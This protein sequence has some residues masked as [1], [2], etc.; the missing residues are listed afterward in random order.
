MIFI[1][2]IMTF[3]MFNYAFAT[4]EAGE[5][6]KLIVKSANNN[7]YYIDINSLGYT[8]NHTV[9]AW[10]KVVPADK[11][12]VFDRFKHLRLFGF[13]NAGAQYFK[14]YCE[15]DCRRR[16]LRFLITTVY[17]GEDNIVRRDETLNVRWTSIPR[18]SSFDMIRDIVCKA[19]L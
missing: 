14:V 10:Y 7:D 13:R 3:L 18:E 1:L 16:V 8:D 5:K 17:D 15:I 2:V 19:G 4:D 12:S 11:A 6:W 9:I